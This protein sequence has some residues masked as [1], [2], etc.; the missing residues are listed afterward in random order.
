MCKLM[1]DQTLIWLH[2]HAPKLT[3]FGTQV[4]SGEIFEKIKK[5]KKISSLIHQE[6]NPIHPSW[7]APVQSAIKPFTFLYLW[8]NVD[9]MCLQY[10]TLYWFTNF[11]CLI[12]LLFHLYDHYLMIT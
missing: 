12:I 6:W 5:K 4:K 11:L 1:Q 10:I 8:I 3:K 7:K 2:E 9:V